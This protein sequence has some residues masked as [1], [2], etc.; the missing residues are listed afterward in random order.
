MLPTL[1]EVRRGLDSY[2]AELEEE[3]Y[4]NW[5]GLKEDLAT[6]PIVSKY[7]WLLTSRVA[8]AARRLGGRRG[9][10][11]ER[12]AVSGMLDEAV[13]ELTDSFETRLTAKTVYVAGEQLPFR[14]AQ[15]KVSNEPRRDMRAELY[16]SIL[17]AIEEVNPILEERTLILHRKARELGFRSYAELSLSFKSFRIEELREAASLLCSETEAL[18]SSEMEKRLEEKAG[19]GLR[20]AERHDIAYLFRATEFDRYFPAEK[21]VGKLLKTIR[22]MGLDLRDVKLD[23]EARPRKSPRAFCAPVRVPWDV[24]L[25]VMPKGG[26]DDYMALFHEAGHALHAAYTSPELPAELRRLWEGA[27]AET[28]AFLMEY[29]LT[30]ESWL[31]EHTELRGGELRMFLR[32]Q[33]LY[34][35]YYLRRYA[36]KVEYELKLHSDGLADARDTYVQELQSKLVFKQPHQYYLYDVDDMMYSADYLTAWLLE[37]QLRSH[38]ESELGERWY[39]R[40]EAGRLLRGLWSQ[41]GKP[42][43]RDLLSEAGYSRLDARPLIEDVKKMME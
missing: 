2:L 10:L 42:S 21:M 13:K 30:S 31:S 29:L 27:I 18:Y 25:V 15:V 1:D 38:L 6:T 35:L 41:G 4:L 32:L 9:K 43:V 7:R 39:M 11:L 24:R 33:G 12:F 8:E 14:L 3:Y 22:Y 17:D 36:G 23:V 26:F 5:A 16:R 28:Y 37:A 19:V 40:E 34:K 20:E